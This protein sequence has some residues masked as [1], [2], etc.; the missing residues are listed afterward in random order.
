MSNSRLAEAVNSVWYNDC[1]IYR[2]HHC[3]SRTH[4]QIFNPFWEELYDGWFVTGAT[5]QQCKAIE[6][7]IRS[8]TNSNLGNS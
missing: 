5:D 7:T 8:W 6:D 2:E 3:S 1:V 4:I